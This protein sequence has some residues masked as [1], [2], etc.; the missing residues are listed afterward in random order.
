MIKYKKYPPVK[1]KDIYQ[2]ICHSICS[3]ASADK[4]RPAYCIDVL[5]WERD[6]EKYYRMKFK[7]IKLRKG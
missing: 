2:L 4:C 6:I 3:A 7:A 5:G 1:K